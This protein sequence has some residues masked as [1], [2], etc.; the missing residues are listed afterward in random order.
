MVKP[1]PKQLKIMSYNIQAGISQSHAR[2]YVTQGWR[3][4][5]PHKQRLENL[6]EISHYIKT[7]DVVGLQEID[8]GSFRS[9]FINQIE[10]LAKKC[11]FPYWYSQK[12]RDMG[13]VAKFCNACLSRVK[14]YHVDYHKL[15]GL[16]PGRGAIRLFY[17]NKEAPLVIIMVHLSLGPVSQRIQIDYLNQLVKG[18]Q[19]V[20]VMGDLNCGLDDL[21]KSNL[22]TKPRLRPVNYLFNTYPSWKPTKILDYILVSDSIQVVETSVLNLPFSDHLPVTV[23]AQLPNEIMV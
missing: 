16:I 14:P 21:E 15:P 2:E 20:I 8:P 7:F 18:Y 17:G 13:K 6:D 10:F 23:T 11:H 1:L 12:N 5:L 4:F 22:F 19:H 9:G 3:H